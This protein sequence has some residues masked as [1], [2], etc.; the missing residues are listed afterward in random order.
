MTS[1]LPP[2]ITE[3]MIPGNQPANLPLVSED[4][5][6][7]TIEEW[8]TW[9]VGEGE[10]T[11]SVCTEVIG[12]YLGSHPY[13]PDVDHGAWTTCWQVPALEQVVCEDC[14]E[15]LLTYEEAT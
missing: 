6:E 4:F 14:R 15:H 9:G 10:S 3:S 11:C 8:E 1:N 7:V 12:Y 13:M 2:G 5:E